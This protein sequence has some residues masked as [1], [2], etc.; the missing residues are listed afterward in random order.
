MK[1]TPGSDTAHSLNEEVKLH[2]ALLAVFLCSIF[3]CET[4]RQE[5]T[6]YYNV[7]GFIYSESMNEW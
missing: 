7:K 2:L 1:E 4:E 6:H 3:R 5:F